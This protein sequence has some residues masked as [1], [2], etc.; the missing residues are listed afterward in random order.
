[1]KKVL[2]LLLA[3][4]SFGYSFSL[5]AEWYEVEGEAVIVD[6]NVDI[7][8]ELAVRNALKQA[9][10]YAGASV[11]SLQTFNGGKILTDSFQVRMDGEI[12]DIRLKSEKIKKGIITVN[13]VTDIVADRNKCLSAGYQKSMSLL[14]FNIAHREH[15]SYGAIYGINES[16]S[17]LLYQSLRKNSQTFD[18][19]EFINQNIGFSGN[20]LPL[21]G[22]LTSEEVKQMSKSADSQYIIMGSIT[23][24]STL[25]PTVNGL[26]KLLADELPERNF[27]LN[28]QVFDGFNGSLL[29]DKSYSKVTKWEF[30]KHRI[31]DTDTLKF[32]RSQFGESLQLII[33]DV[34]FDLDASLQCKLV[35]ARVIAVD[36]N[37]VDINIGRNNGLKL[38]DKFVIK[39]TGSYIDQFG[40]SR[41]KEVNSS[42]EVEVTNLYD[43]QARLITVTRQPTA[44]VQIDDL[45]ILN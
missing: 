3:C 45:V 30:G 19:R 29:F 27:R 2:L 24:L 8:R 22:N 28:V 42:S 31:V 4:C 1:M 15:A 5:Y 6:N 37:E 10:L 7:A 16:F 14:R 18:A 25:K 41:K 21:R 38:G 33:D 36:G 26:A 20:S 17:R 35:E 40:I 44:N 34:L 23:D 43:Q 9:L 13:V 32:W 39:H 12:R 11:S